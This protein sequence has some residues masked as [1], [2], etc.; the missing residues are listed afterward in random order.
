MTVVEAMRQ[1][2]LRGEVDR[3]FIGTDVLF[4][5][6]TQA[7]ILKINLYKEA[8]SCFYPKFCHNAYTIK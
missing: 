5:S 3:V 2:R 7:R 8:P 1:I 4:L 6:N